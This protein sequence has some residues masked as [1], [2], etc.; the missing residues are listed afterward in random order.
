MIGEIL[1]ASGA[2]VVAIIVFIVMFK[3]FKVLLKAIIIPLILLVGYVV[4]AYT[5][6]WFPF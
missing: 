3:I 5:Q 4:L 1:G 6:G 2:L